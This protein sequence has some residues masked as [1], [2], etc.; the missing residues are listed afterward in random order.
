MILLA[1]AIKCILNQHF[2]RFFHFLSLR[3]FALFT[4]VMLIYLK[5]NI[6]QPLPTNNRRM[7]FFLPRLRWSSASNVNYV[8]CESPISADSSNAFYFHGFIDTINSKKVFQK[9]YRT[10][11]GFWF[12]ICSRFIPLKTSSLRLYIYSSVVNGV[13]CHTVRYISRNL[14]FSM[15][16]YNSCVLNLHLCRLWHF[17]AKEMEKQFQNFYIRT[18]TDNVSKTQICTWLYWMFVPIKYLQE[19]ID[20]ATFPQ[21]MATNVILFHNFLFFSVF[22]CQPFIKILDK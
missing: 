2:P 4:K 21:H 5:L 7:I 6:E 19:K 18:M 22:F 1:A 9:E 11:L 20:V 15:W 8:C 17:S 12:I 3:K 14:Q 13:M 16:T 10:H